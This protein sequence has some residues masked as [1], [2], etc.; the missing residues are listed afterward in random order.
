MTSEHI[1]GIARTHNSTYP[2]G[3]V[4]C[5]KDSFVSNPT[6]VFQINFYSKSPTH[7][8]SANRYG[9]C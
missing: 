7:R 3:G 9:L 6:L 4:S 2:K 8:K 1:A 5:T